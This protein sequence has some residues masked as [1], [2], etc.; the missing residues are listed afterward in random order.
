MAIEDLKNSKMM[1]HLLSSLEQ[2]QDIGHYGRLTFVMVGRH[3]LSEDDLIECL[4][5]DP[6][7]NETK[8]KV[9]VKQVIARGYN[10]PKP[11]RIMEWMD[12]QE[13][14]IC[15]DVVQLGSCNVY[16]DLT[17]P[18]ST[19]NKISNYYEQQ[20]QAEEAHSST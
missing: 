7:C 16:R 12:Q 19:Y 1:G 2:G 15:P 9:L 17:F 10:P 3:F 11:Q 8:A 14:P 18:E 6:D 5:K 20:V 13:F 4:T